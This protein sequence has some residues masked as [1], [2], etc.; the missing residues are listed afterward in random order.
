MI[1]ALVTIPVALFI[2]L[3]IAALAGQRR[4]RHDRRPRRS[5]ASAGG[6]R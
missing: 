4:P 1:F 6:W 3:V 5:R 2:G